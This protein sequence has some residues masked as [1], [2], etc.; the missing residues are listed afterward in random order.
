MQQIYDGGKMKRGM[1]GMFDIYEE[2]PQYRSGL[3][4]LR[5]TAAE[6]AQELLKCYSDLEAVPFF[7][8]DNCHG[9]DFHYETI[10]RMLQAIEFWDF[11]YNNRYFVRWTVSLNTTGEKVGT[12][13]MFHRLADD[14]FNHYGVLRIDLQSRCETR[15]IIG[16]IL[17]IARNHFY[18]AFEVK[19]ILTKAVPEAAQRILALTEAGFTP[20]DKKLMTY[21]HYFWTKI[22]E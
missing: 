9:D 6:D 7:N 15:E 2:C 10:E 3:V 16:D 18:T 12:V 14:E 13:E 19:D 17:N 21:D 20:L 22:P 5:K 8:S 1:S 11:S 4:S